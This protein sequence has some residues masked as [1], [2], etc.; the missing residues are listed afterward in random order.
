MF[1]RPSRFRS[2]RANLRLPPH[3]AP[4]PVPQG[5]EEAEWDSVPPPATEPAR[6][7]TPAAVQRALVAPTLQAASLL[8]ADQAAQSGLAAAV[9]R[10]QGEVNQSGAA[11]AEAGVTPLSLSAWQRQPAPTM[12]PP[13]TQLA[14]V[15]RAAV[16]GQALGEVGAA[17]GQFAPYIPATERAAHAL[18]VVQRHVQAGA[19]QE[20]LL[21]ALQ[22]QAAQEPFGAQAYA[23]AVQR[24][25]AQDA[26]LQRAM[27]A[28]ALQ[29]QHAARTHELAEL[30]GQQ[31]AQH[32]QTVTQ[33]VQARQG[34]GEPLPAAVLRHLE[35][36]LNADLSRV[37]VHT[38]S[39]AAQ[40]ASSLQATAFTT[41]TDIYFA[42]NQYNPHS[43]SGLELLAHEATHVVQQ[44]QG[45][46]QAGLDPDAGK[47]QEAQQMG[48]RLA[49]MGGPGGAGAGPAPHPAT[50]AAPGTV[51]RQIKKKGK[52]SEL[53]LK[54]PELALRKA[55]DDMSS[56]KQGAPANFYDSQYQTLLKA[57]YKEGKAY[58]LIAA[59]READDRYIQKFGALDI[60]PANPGTVLADCDDVIDLLKTKKRKVDTMED[61][62][63]TK[64]HRVA[65]D[66]V[67]NVV[68]LTD[69]DVLNLMPA[70][71]DQY[72]HFTQALFKNHIPD[73]VQTREAMEE[74][75]ETLV[76]NDHSNGGMFSVSGKG[77]MFES[78]VD[79][80]V[81]GSGG[82]V[83]VSKQ[84]QMN[85]TRS[86]D[87][88][89][90]ATQTL[91]DAK[92]Y[93]TKVPLGTNNDQHDDYVRIL[94]KGY[95][96]DGGEKISKVCYVFPGKRQ[97]ELNTHLKVNLGGGKK[98]EVA[99]ISKGT[100]P[101]LKHL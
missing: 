94:R 33:R 88:Y 72:P 4:A 27:T 90:S 31:A 98:V 64:K 92:F 45:R 58:T 20:T 39:E 40:L 89:D 36:G 83:T 79:K 19:D 9:Q 67:L 66:A 86:S 59:V 2:P 54:F 49:V 100:S 43:A 16:T 95:D 23:A 65:V 1:E 21:A 24:V 63:I 91:Y 29:G 12:P 35:A 82:R 48:K 28:H 41:G 34:G 84:G 76:S 47:E 51:Q 13:P 61:K 50:Q 26:A 30:Q 60:K 15:Q 73:M 44:A 97:A 75:C 10:A 81:L 85:Q 53:Y 3:L 55:F 52:R 8:R 78:F 96:G 101:Q 5:P 25:Q 17:Y 18:G 69:Q 70:K 46:V 99:Y 87:S 14:P 62:L 77:S 80:T 7:T 68:P 57:I 32:L 74:V 56:R 93:Y 71:G 22:R 42:A 38:D 11:L 6:R 37:R